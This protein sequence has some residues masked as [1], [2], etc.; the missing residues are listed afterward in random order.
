MNLCIQVAMLKGLPVNTFNQ[1]SHYAQQAHR[2]WHLEVDRRYAPKM[3][4]LIQ[5]AEE[6]GCVEE[7]W[8]CHAHE[9]E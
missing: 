1:L 5:C 3:K 9:S 7:F 6:Y 8:G 4:G 2:S